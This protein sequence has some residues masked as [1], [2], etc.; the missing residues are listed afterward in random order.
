MEK[1]KKIEEGIYKIPIIF[2]ES[3]EQQRDKLEQTFIA[4]QRRLRKF[5]IRNGWDNLVEENFADR[6]EIYDD[7]DKLIQRAIKITNST[8]ST[9]FPKQFSACLENKVFMS[10]SP[11][12]YSQIY[13]DDIDKDAFEKLITHE[14]AHRLHIRILNGN[15]E[16]MG[17]IWFFEGFALYAAGQFEKYNPKMETIEIWEIVKSDKRESYKKYA[18]VFRYFLQKASIQELIEHAGDKDFLDWLRKINRK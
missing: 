8:P 17:P 6:A 13:T 5:A 3:L 4:A 15:E 14:M 2:S 9:E 7:Q 10:V 12:L 1:V 18:P 11:G 16:A